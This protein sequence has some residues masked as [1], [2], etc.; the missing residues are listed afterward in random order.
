VGSCLVA[1]RP[2][3]VAL[4]GLVHPLLNPLGENHLQIAQEELANLAIVSR[5]KCNNALAVLAREG[6]LALKYG[7]I[8][9]RDRSALQRR[10]G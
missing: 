9:I 8:H 3:R 5:Q 1:L 10:S 4:L 6:A 7:A 2:R